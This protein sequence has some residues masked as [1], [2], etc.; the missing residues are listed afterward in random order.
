MEATGRPAF[1][2]E[3]RR[4][5]TGDASAIERILAA[6]LPGDAAS[7]AAVRAMSE[8]STEHVL[9]AIDA[10]AGVVGLMGL[11][12]EGI[13]PPL[14]EPTEQP[15]SL[16]LA[17]VD[18]DHRGRGVGSALADA[19]EAHAVAAG[20]DRLIVVSGARSRDV[21]YA[22][23]QSRYGRMAVFEA[24]HFAP[25][26]ERVAWSVPLPRPRTLSGGRS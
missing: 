14:F 9:V 13:R 5:R 17:Y 18:P 6:W 12:F 8:T 26:V 1:S 24:D 16:I 7:E 15:A 10:T 2:G 25:G 21:G 4:V 19:L 22:F 11:E 3:L 20:C 23:W